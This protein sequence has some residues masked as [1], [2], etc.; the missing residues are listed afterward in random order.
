MKEGWMR[1][2][3]T[4]AMMGASAVA[5]YTAMN[6]NARKKMA[7]MVTGTAQKMADKAEQMMR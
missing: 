2:A 4:G 7:R 6:R 1:G 5:L 3:F